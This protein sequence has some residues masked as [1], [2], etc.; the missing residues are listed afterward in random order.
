MSSPLEIVVLVRAM[1]KAHDALVA[2][3]ESADQAQYEDHPGAYLS[4]IVRTA[5][6][7]LAETTPLLMGS[8]EADDDSQAG[9]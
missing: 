8:P 7:A 5:K 3:Y 4:S 9:R 1:Q 2:I 6:E